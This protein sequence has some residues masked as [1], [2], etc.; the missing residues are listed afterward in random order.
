M[1]IKY[2]LLTVV[3]ALMCQYSYSQPKTN[4]SILYSVEDNKPVY[5]FRSEPDKENIGNIYY[6]IKN[7]KV[8]VNYNIEYKG[9][10]EKKTEDYD[11]VYYSL[12]PDSITGYEQNGLALCSILFDHNLK[13]KEIK[14]LRRYGYDNSKF[15]YDKVVKFI[16]RKMSRNWRKKE[17]L[18]NSPY[19]FFIDRVM[20]R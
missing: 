11:S 6:F 17:V 12:V 7:K 2:L 13:I 4:D 15:N 5:L 8:K 20:I 18:N 19:Y 1:I 9:G 16:I 14:I 3:F 10:Q